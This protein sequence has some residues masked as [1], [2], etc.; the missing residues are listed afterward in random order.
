LS[1]PVNGHELWSLEKISEC[2]HKP[3]MEKYE[4]E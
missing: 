4:L 1:H 2:V 3:K